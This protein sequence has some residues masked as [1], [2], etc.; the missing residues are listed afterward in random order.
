MKSNLERKL[1]M[2]GV[3]VTRYVSSR[4]EKMILNDPFDPDIKVLMKFHKGLCDLFLSVSDAPVCPNCKGSGAVGH[5][6]GP[7]CLMCNGHG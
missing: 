6:D 2:L 7:A 4:L 3:K 5:E 1:L